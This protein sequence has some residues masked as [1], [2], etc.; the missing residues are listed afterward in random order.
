MPNTPAE[1]RSLVDPYKSLPGRLWRIAKA[2]AAETLS[3]LNVWSWFRPIEKFEAG[4]IV[5]AREFLDEHGWVILKGVFNES[6]IARLREGVARSV[7]EGWTGDLISNPYIGADHFVLDERLLAIVR[8]FLPGTPVHFGDASIS[9]GFQTALA[10]HKDNPDR[11]NQAAPDWASPY[12]ILRFGLYLQSHTRHSGGLALR[13][14]SHWTVDTSK[15]RPF[16]VPTEPGDVV[17]WTLRTTHSGFATRL[18]GLVNAFVPLTI[19]S[20]IVGTERYA[21]PKWLFRPM[22]AT[23]RMALFATFGVDDAHLRRNIDFMKTRDYAVRSWAASE[24]PQ[25]V[26]QMARDKGVTVI[27]M[28]EQARHIDPSAL[29]VGYVPPPA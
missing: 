23:P 16:A 26:L 12:T 27:D 28:S 15:G 18:R 11:R 29:N 22:S 9:C 8:G 14:R 24:Y 7:A 1:A 10:F 3:M 20:L 19:M 21:P 5:R 13:D 2:T 17:V 4:D 25:A 6:Q